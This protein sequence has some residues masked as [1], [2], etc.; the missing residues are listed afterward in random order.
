MY[1]AVIC[2]VLFI[3]LTSHHTLCETT[4][5]ACANHCKLVMKTTLK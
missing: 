2:N 1:N 5:K 4:V 3:I